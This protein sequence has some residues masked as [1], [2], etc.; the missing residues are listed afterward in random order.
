[1]VNI[2]KNKTTNKLRLFFLFILSKLFT[3]YKF[4]SPFNK[5]ITEYNQSNFVINIKKLGLSAGK[6][7]G[8]NLNLF[9]LT[10]LFLK[11]LKNHS[12]ESNIDCIIEREHSFFEMRLKD[13]NTYSNFSMLLSSDKQKFLKRFII[14]IGRTKLIGG[15]YN[16]ISYKDHKKELVVKIPVVYI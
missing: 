13:N 11:T 3:S 4:I 12:P 5:L 9:K 15:N 10:V 6:T 14:P 8:S 16:I 7:M 2:I 1:M